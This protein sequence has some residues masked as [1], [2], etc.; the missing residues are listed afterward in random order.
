[1]K[2]NN[3]KSKAFFISIISI[4]TIKTIAKQEYLNDSV[5]LDKILHAIKEGDL[6]L[7]KRYSSLI[8]N[9][10]LNKDLLKNKNKTY[11]LSLDSFKVLEDISLK[12]HLNQS[13][14]VNKILLSIITKDFEYLERYVNF[15]KNNNIGGK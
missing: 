8:K 15:F 6:N 5:L 14:T 1:M 4:D 7:L 2:T 9:R 11:A 10:D 12:D 13:S 3:K